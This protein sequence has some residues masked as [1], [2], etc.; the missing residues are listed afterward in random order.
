M[1]AAPSSLKE[2]V[3]SYYKQKGYAITENLSFE[4]FSGTDHTFDLMIQRG[5]EKRLV[6]LRDWNRTVGVNM[7]IKMDN[8]C[9]DVKIPKPIM[10]SHQF[11]DHAKGYAHR[12]GILLLT[13]ADIRK[14]GP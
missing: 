5:Q 4:G 13:K 11:S 6:W 10:I 8:A 2:L 1:T 9:E 12:R 14:R 7:V 3:I